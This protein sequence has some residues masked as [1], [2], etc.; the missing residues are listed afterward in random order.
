M[1][2]LFGN[3]LTVSPTRTRSAIAIATVAPHS[4]SA[5]QKFQGFFDER[6]VSLMGASALLDAGGNNSAG[7]RRSPTRRAGD[8]DRA[9]QILEPILHVRETRA[10]LRDH[11]VEP[12][13]S[14]GHLESRLIVSL[15]QPHG[16]F[17]GAGVLLHVLECLQHAEVGGRLDVLGVAADAISVNVNRQG[18]LARLS[19]ERGSQSS[20]GQ[21][22]W[23]D[24]AGQVAQRLQRLVGVALQ[25]ADQGL[26]LGGVL[27]R[28][29]TP[30]PAPASPSAPP[31]LACKPSG[32]C[33]P[34]AAPPCPACRHQPLPQRA[35]HFQPL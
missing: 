7:D 28:S 26:R 13:P 11:R 31:E 35:E 9:A 27:S 24:A 16:R 19:L 15:R 20:V 29:R 23:V 5:S 6:G 32:G 1:S 18:R 30:P 21:Q 33:A 14:F 12:P 17:R 34:A 25:R 10:L 3:W 4:A 2:T 22:R 8:L